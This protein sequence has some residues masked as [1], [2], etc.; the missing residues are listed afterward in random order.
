VRES[1]N[2]LLNFEHVCFLLGLSYVLGV[3]EGAKQ[4][5]A[6]DMNDLCSG[7]IDIDDVR[8]EFAPYFVQTFKSLLTVMENQETK[9]R[10]KEEKER[11]QL[12]SQSVSSSTTTDAVPPGVASS[13]TKSSADIL[14]EPRTPDQPTHPSNPKWSGSSTA[15]QDEEATK[16][17]LSLFLSETMT[18][19][20][21]DFRRVHW[22]K[23]GLRVELAQTLPLYL[24]RAD[25]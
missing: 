20:E 4:L 24:P 17:L 23:S 12:Y 14:S 16:M 15:S 9:L 21:A 8:K 19:L 3:A 2:G 22:Q 7:D 25:N 11:S 6:V 10:M 18:I 1:W 13:R 5:G